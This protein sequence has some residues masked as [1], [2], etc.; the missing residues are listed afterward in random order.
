MS[1]RKEERKKE[2]KRDEDNFNFL[3]V[4]FWAS[5]GKGRMNNHAELK[6][7]RAFFASLCL[8][9]SRA[10]WWLMLAE[11]EVIFS[12]VRYMDGVE[13]EEEEE[14][15]GRG[16]L[17]FLVVDVEERQRGRRSV[18]HTTTAG[19]KIL[20]QQQLKNGRGVFL[21]RVRE[22]ER[23]P[24]AFIFLCVCLYIFIRVAM[25]WHG[26]SSTYDRL[27]FSQESSRYYLDMHR[28]REIRVYLC[29]RS[30]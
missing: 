21:H 28:V 5:A 15:S 2:K 14:V 13:E 23:E 17:L 19:G 30:S 18:S 11:G 1:K 8:V 3:L 9:G 24:W 20:Q 22:R 12:C 10:C 26:R 27:I 29:I 4:G 6:D 16:Q 25:D 7:K